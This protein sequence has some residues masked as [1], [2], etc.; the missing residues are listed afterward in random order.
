MLGEQWLYV[1]P[2]QKRAIVNG[3]GSPVLHLH[4]CW[5]CEDR[6]LLLFPTAIKRTSRSEVWLNALLRLKIYDGRPTFHEEGLPVLMCIILTNMKYKTAGVD[7]AENDYLTTQYKKIATRATRPE[8]IG[9]VGLFSGAFDFSKYKNHLLVSSTDG[10]GTKTM[11]ARI[12][13]QFETIGADIVNHSINDILTSGAEPLFFLDYLATGGITPQQKIAIV[14]SV[15]TACRKHNIALLGGETADMPDLYPKNEFD[16]A[17][18]IVGAVKKTNLIT[19]QNIT[20][21][22]QLIGLPSAGL[23][24]NGYSLVRHIFK[25]N[26]QQKILSKHHP[27][28]KTTLGAALLV[29]HKSYEKELRPYLKHIQGLAHITGGGIEGNLQRG[30]S[31]QCVRGCST[32]R[33]ANASPIPTHS[34]AR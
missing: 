3:G 10:V 8:V 24:T 16:L 33:V 19:G 9:G 2:L 13:N 5:I 4:C 11:I 20:A 28:L 18:T 23:H 26:K 25:L 31:S 30:A 27:E 29:P 14:K 22:D 12:M 7:V 32:Q 1:L 34:S 15:A 17:G 21:G 6:G